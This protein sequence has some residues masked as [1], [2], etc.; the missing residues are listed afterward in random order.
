M[1]NPPNWSHTSVHRKLILRNE[2]RHWF[3]RQSNPVG[4]SDWSVS[5]V[6]GSVIEDS[7]LAGI[8]F[9]VSVKT[10]NLTAI[11]PIDDARLN[12]FREKYSHPHIWTLATGFAE[13]PDRL[14][15]PDRLKSNDPSGGTNCNDDSGI[16]IPELDY[17]GI[18]SRK[19]RLVFKIFMKWL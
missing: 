1:K 6:F 14:E 2:N 15:I 11:N 16:L 18:E 3:Y 7:K 19:L 8:R 4:V 10:E 9:M 13:S 12:K 5:P 17:E